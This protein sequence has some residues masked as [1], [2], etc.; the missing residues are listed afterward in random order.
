M[1][2]TLDD[3]D[4]DDKIIWKASVQHHPVFAKYYHDI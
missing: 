2:K 1:K 4:K 3:W